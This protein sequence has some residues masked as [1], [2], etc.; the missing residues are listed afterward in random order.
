VPEIAAS[1][2]LVVVT[3]ARDEVVLAIAISIQDVVPIAKEAPA[4]HLQVAKEYC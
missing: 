1:I 2:D 3:L 4:I